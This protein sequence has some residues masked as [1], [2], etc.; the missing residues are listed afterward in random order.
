[1]MRE[2]WSRRLRATN[3]RRAVVVALLVLLV[4]SFGVNVYLA[5]AA[6]HHFETSVSLRLD[7][8]GLKTYAME[9]VKPP[10]DLPVLVFFGDSR[11][12]MWSEPALPTGYRI[13]NRGI[14]YQTTAQMLLRFDADAAQLHP[15][16]VVLE[17]GVNDLKSIAAFPERR[18]EIVADCEAN[19]ERL[20]HLCRKADATVV[21]V[22]VFGIGDVSLWRRPFWSSDIAFAVREVNVFLRRLVEEKVVLFDASPVLED[23]RGD[24]HGAYQLDHLHLSSAGYT[25]LNL[26]L[27][28]LLLSLPK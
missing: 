7:P 18:A 25:A 5:R 13:V 10:L 21:L 4:G 17:A 8:G 20:V 28:P 23:G 3:G 6:V 1:M 27:A 24:I 22:T 14:G 11:A 9:R 15:N 26:K 16:A 12:R 2:P 19:L